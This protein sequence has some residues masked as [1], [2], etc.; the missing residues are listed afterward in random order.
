MLFG[1]FQ[2]VMDFRHPDG[3]KV[4]VFLPRRSLLVMTGE[5]RYL[6][7]HGSVLSHLHLSLHCLSVQNHPEKDR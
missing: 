5:A 2:V 4:A 6:W 1:I 3:Q 7:S